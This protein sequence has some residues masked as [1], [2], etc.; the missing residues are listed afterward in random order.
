MKL[1]VND[2]RARGHKVTEQVL[3]VCINYVNCVEEAHKTQ[4]S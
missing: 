1:A 4:Q 2:T 3:N